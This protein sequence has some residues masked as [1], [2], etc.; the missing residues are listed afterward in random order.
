MAYSAIKGA[1]CYTYYIICAS[2]DFFRISVPVPVPAFHVFQFQAMAK[3]LV[4][5]RSFVHS[6]A[7]ALPFGPCLLH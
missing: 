5:T 2:D 7:L 6:T 4:A 3:V 1:W